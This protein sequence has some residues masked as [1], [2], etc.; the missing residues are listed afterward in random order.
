MRS[1]HTSNLL[2]FSFERFMC[3][4]HFWKLLRTKNL[5]KVLLLDGRKSGDH[6]GRYK[7]NPSLFETKSYFVTTCPLSKGNLTW[8]YVEWYKDMLLSMMISGNTIPRIPKQHSLRFTN[9]WIMIPNMFS[10]FPRRCVHFRI[11]NHMNLISLP[12]TL[13]VS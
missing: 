2:R 1:A 3:N 8:W 6:E 5:W 10:T 13:V 9:F 4:W 11:V 7:R 12:S